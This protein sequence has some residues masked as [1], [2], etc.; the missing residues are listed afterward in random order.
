VGFWNETEKDIPMKTLAT[1]NQNP[2]TALSDT[3]AREILRSVSIA[4]ME[5]GAVRLETGTLESAAIIKFGMRGA[6]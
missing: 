3:V 2:S 4:L 5:H 6:S 1:T